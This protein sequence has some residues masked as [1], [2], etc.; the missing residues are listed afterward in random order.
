[1]D[2]N[3]S[4]QPTPRA[5]FPATLKHL[6]IQETDPLFIY[7]ILGA[8]TLT[9]LFL[10]LLVINKPLEYDEAYTFV[11]FAS[12]SF[13][14]IL[15]DYSAPNNHILHTILVGLAYR[16]FG[17]EPWVLRLPALAAGTLIVPAMYFTARRFFSRPQALAA[18]GLVA[19]ANWFISYSANGRGYTLL[20][21][22]A[23]LLTNFA[24]LLVT[25]QRNSRGG[26]EWESRA[27]LIAFAVTGALG[28]YTIPIFLYPMAGISLWVA[29]TYLAAAEPWRDRLRRL[30]VFLGACLAA[31]LL[32][33]VLY[34]P[35]I[36]F[37]TG[38]SSIVNN[39]IV[40]SLDW[41]AFLENLDPR[42]EKTWRK[43]MV[44][45]D[46]SARYLLSGGFLL[47]LLFYRKL[48][49]QK[50]P[51]QI[52][53]VLGPVVLL[54][55]QRVTPLPRMWIYLEA[56][57]LMFA[58][59]GLVWLAGLLVRKAAGPA[60]TERILSAG[61]LLAVVVACA[62][63]LGSRQQSVVM[64]RGPLPEQF[65]AEYIVEHVRSEDIIIATGPVHIRTAYYVIIHDIPFERF[66]QRGQPLEFQSALVVL[67]TNSK[68][69]TPQK[70]VDFFELTP[71]LEAD[72]AELVYEYGAVQVYSVPARQ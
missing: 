40:E 19:L 1:M 9:G 11:Y 56:F 63:I 33:L 5:S 28:F 31:G 60:R 46:P 51:M 47:S 14:Y 61:V 10:R 53:L 64:S 70:V 43:W 69:N 3:P 17:G 54:V 2:H 8:I 39:E 25:R 13:K 52:F 30:A 50:L 41:S 37:G 27:A 58:A 71:V 22:L 4:N 12:R 29:A 45:I 6:F 35:V 57:Y 20:I 18:A 24:A 44:R 59:A 67:R 49:N 23:L 32:T 62:A 21:L 34:S 55:L 7:L 68:Q 42:L 15:A 16:I 65:A 36:V 26:T 66:Y 48:S 72:S 38:F